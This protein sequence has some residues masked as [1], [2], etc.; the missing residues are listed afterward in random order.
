MP[1]GEPG[2]SGALGA[3]GAW[4]ALVFGGRMLGYFAPRGLLHVQLWHEAAGISVLTPSRLTGGRYEVFPVAGWKK[5]ASDYRTLAWL[6]QQEHGVALPSLVEVF[7]I[8]RALAFDLARAVTG[9]A[10]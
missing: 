10:S 9:I 2:A 7:R 6:V 1:L 4:K 8:E 5:R 3:L